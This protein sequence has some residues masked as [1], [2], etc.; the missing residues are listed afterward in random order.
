MFPRLSHRRHPNKEVALN[1]MRRY[2]DLDIDL[3]TLNILNILI[4]F[5][6]M[7]FSQNYTGVCVLCVCVW[8]G[9]GGG[10]HVDVILNTVRLFKVLKPPSTLIYYT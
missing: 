3:W 1:C 8:G 9:G 2:G 6:N 10:L 4:T 7:S 5:E